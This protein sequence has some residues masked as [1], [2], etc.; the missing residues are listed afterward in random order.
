MS[1][2][3]DIKAYFMRGRKPTQG[4]YHDTFEKVYLKDQTVPVD[5]LSIGEELLT[6]SGGTLTWDV[7]A[8]GTNAYATLTENV[9]LDIQN[10]AIGRFLNLAVKQGG[11]GGYT[12]SLPAGSL[13]GYGGAGVISLS[14]AVGKIDVISIF[15]SNHGYLFTAIT[16]FTAA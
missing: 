1:Y 5:A 11:S 6:S 4:E 14:S 12:L 7:E 10:M 15:R 16:D 2:L 3:T 13:V 9:T 8:V